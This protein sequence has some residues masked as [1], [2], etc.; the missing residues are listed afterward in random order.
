MNPQ[1]QNTN[2]PKTTSEVIIDT[3]SGFINYL[4]KNSKLVIFIFVGAL[5]LSL[6]GVG[7]V[8]Y[9][10]KKEQELQS[11]YYKI[12]KDYLKKKE[13]FDKALDESKTKTDLKKSKKTAQVE[14]EKTPLVLP[15]GEIEKDYGPQ[16]QA[17]KD[18]SQKKPSSHASQLST[19]LL[20]S[21]FVK[22]QK[23][24]LAK[25][26]LQT[27][28]Q[29][30]KP[31]LLKALMLN[32]LGTVYSNLE[33]CPAAIKTWDQVLEQKKFN[34]LH[35]E[36][37]LRQAICYEH[38]KDLASAEKK[39]IEASQKSL[40]DKSPG[41]ESMDIGSLSMGGSETSKEA[42]RNLKILKIRKNFEN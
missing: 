31:S 20:S 27:A 6:A 39:Y 4:Q 23:P 17:L 19:L 1:N 30:A 32:Q 36:A 35:K 21:L 3:S 29:S 28:L 11:E 18:L 33:D 8:L 24:D 41:S 16:I 34:Y 26:V 42:E 37:L 38:Q 40:T 25:E 9:E 12:E 13:A 7:L 2:T 10:T 22:Y 14:P 15:S 5:V